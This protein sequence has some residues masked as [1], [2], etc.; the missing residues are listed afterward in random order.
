M[1]HCASHTPDGKPN[2]YRFNNPREKC[3]A[4]KRRF[5]HVCGLCY[6]PKNPTHA[7]GDKTRQEDT[8][9]TA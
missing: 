4:K 3:K 6:S 5:E 9:G 7:C 8:Q 2:C 1:Q